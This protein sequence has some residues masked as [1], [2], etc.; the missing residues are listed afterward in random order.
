MVLE[1]DRRNKGANAGRDRSINLGTVGDPVRVTLQ[2]TCKLN[3]LRNVLANN[4]WK[5]GEMF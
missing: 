2:L 3:E 1:A 4:R 5:N